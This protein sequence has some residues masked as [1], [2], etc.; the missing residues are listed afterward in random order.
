MTAPILAAAA[1]CIA[2]TVVHV[3]SI[4]IAIR[5]FRRGTRG[6]PLSSLPAPVGQ[7]LS[8]SIV[9]PLCG[10]DN[11]AA[12]TLS[13]TFELDYPH[14]EILFCV[15]SAKDPVVPLVK[16][17]MAENPSRSARLLVGDDRVS[18]N[19]KLNNVLKG[20]RAAGH[21]WIVIADSNVLMP[22]DYI[23]RLFAS[24][25]ADTGL[26]ASPPI[27]CRPR[28]DLGRNRMRV[29]QHLPGALAVSRRH[30]RLRFCARQNHAVAA[31]RSRC[32]RGHRDAGQGGRRRCRGDQG[33]ARRRSEGAARRSA[34]GAAARPAQRR[35]GLE[36]PVTLGA[37]APREFSDLF[38]AGNPV[39]RRAADDRRRHS[40]KRISVCRSRFA[41]RRSARSGTAPK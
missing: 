9:R 2:V 38:S 13:S 41:S 28:R 3:A 4:A 1:F 15:A 14:Y 25:R 29:P 34:A 5:R 37:P 33:G 39:G 27:G 20:W 8:V 18:P 6:G 11:Y 30:L 31:R 32:R 24:W 22:R 7:N 10:I 16:N 23:Q 26:V 19:P 36:P 17:L 35:R 12:D 21:D 40:G